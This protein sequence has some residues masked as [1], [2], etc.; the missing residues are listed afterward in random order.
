M[1]LTVFKIFAAVVI[2]GLAFADLRGYR[3]F[4][5]SQQPVVKSYTGS[6]GSTSGSYRS[7]GSSGRHK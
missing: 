1:M 6:S 5:G 2:V 4:S 7:G 3:P